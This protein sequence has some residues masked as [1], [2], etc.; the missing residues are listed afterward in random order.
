MISLFVRQYDR[1]YFGQVIGVYPEIAC[2]MTFKCWSSLCGSTVYRG[3]KNL[4]TT[5]DSRSHIT[6]FFCQFL[7][8]LDV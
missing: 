4:E 7:Q 5:L 6:L 1:C 3:E 8:S 2:S